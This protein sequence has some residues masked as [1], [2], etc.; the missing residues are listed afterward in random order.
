M[1]VAGQDFRSQSRVNSGR[2]GV[3]SKFQWEAKMRVLS[4]IFSHAQLLV[5]CAPHEKAWMTMIE[6]KGSHF[7][8]EGIL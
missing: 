5:I 1:A 7:E 4:Q 2:G 6:F 8:R 3:F